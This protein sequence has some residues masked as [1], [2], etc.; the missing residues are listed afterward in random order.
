[1]S[2]EPAAVVDGQDVPEAT[3]QE[4]T[5]GSPWRR[6]GLLALAIIGLTI[7]GLLFFPP[8]D[9]HGDTNCNYPVCFINGNLEFPAP[10]VVFDLTPDTPPVEATGGLTVTFDPTITSTLLTMW[11]VGVLV[12]TVLIVAARARKAIPGGLQNV[13]EWI[14]E[15]L[16]DFA[17]GIGG[18]GARRFIPL[19]AGLFLFIVF[20][21]WSGLIPPVGKIHQLRAPT[22][23][24]NITIGMAL[25]SFFLFWFWGFR[26]NG[27]GYLKKFFPFGEFRKGIGAGIV[28]LF[29]GLIELLLE[30]VKPVTLSM[31]LFGNIYGGEVALGVLTGLTIVLLPAV[32]VGLEF[33]LNVIQALIFSVLTLIFILTAMEHHEEGHETAEAVEEFGHEMAP[34]QLNGRVTQT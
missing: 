5:G 29:V 2:N 4:A 24:V 16:S 14:W 17:I 6:L 23:D 13:V 21:N 25:V 18:D 22:S 28:G 12:A 26:S 31:R 3:A 11:L 33:M 7:V 19:F 9:P 30:F 32:M 1:V 34:A 27:I 20:M 8:V 10:H 15:F